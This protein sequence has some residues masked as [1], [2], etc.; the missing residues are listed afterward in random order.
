MQFVDANNQNCTGGFVGKV[1][2][3]CEIKA[4]TSSS[5]IESYCAGGIVGY[6]DKGCNE[7]H[8]D[9]CSNIGMLNSTNNKERT[10]GLI[11]LIDDGKSNSDIYINK[12]RNGSEHIYGRRVGGAIGDVENLKNLYITGFEQNG[13]IGSNDKNNHSVGGVIGMLDDQHAN[14][15]IQHVSINGEILSGYKDKFGAA[16]GIMGATDDFKECQISDCSIYGN[17]DCADKD[18]RAAF[19]G[20]NYDSSSVKISKSI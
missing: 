5:L 6:C 4:C 11:G 9:D 1:T 14:V 17:I 15:V 3:K 7:V 13:N 8:F 19:V 10:G 12:C 20:R 18:C 2:G 16:G